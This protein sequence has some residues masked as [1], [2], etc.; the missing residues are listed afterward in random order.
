[1]WQRK[2]TIY[3]I[4]VVFLMVIA[5]FLAAD[6]VLK[7][8]SGVTAVLATVT[9]FKYNNR[10]LQMKMC[11]A[12]QLLLLAWVLYFGIIHFYVDK[13]AQKLPFYLCLP[14]V[15]Y[16]MFRMARTGIRH[17]EELVRSADRIR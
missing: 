11:M 6:I 15:A 3:L 17:D 5:A 4:L 2:Q 13:G 9:I 7:A 8:G 16:I 14:I 10:P 1:M 12:G